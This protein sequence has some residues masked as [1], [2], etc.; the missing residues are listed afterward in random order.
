MDLSKIT[1]ASYKDCPVNDRKLFKNSR[2]IMPISIGQK[3]HEGEKFKATIELINRT[4]KESIILIDD[5]V[6][7][8]TMKIANITSSEE[9]LYNRAVKEGEL[10]LERNKSVLNMLKIPYKIITWIK[11]LKHV[12]FAK[13]YTLVESQ[14]NNNIMFKD[15]F[16]KNIEEFLIRYKKLNQDLS[17]NYDIAFSL[18][19]NYLKE[20]CACMCLW[21][22]EECE[23]EVYP[24][25]RNKAMEA[26]YKIL[27]QP[28]Y[29][30]LL[31][32]VALRFKK[33]HVFENNNNQKIN[34]V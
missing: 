5:I 24:S 11:W 8:H 31:R 29:P 28:K 12:E 1:K 23:F 17:F 14:Y 20:E 33:Y 30:N 4:F 26:T 27:I 25:G 32:S 18:C 19:L 22:E 6:Q 2:C 7:R 16:N 15:A 9:E 3:I 34:V 13:S 21:V 10:W